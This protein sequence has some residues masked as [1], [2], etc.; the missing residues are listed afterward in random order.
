MSR[1]DEEAADQRQYVRRY[2]AGEPI[3]DHESD[4]DETGV[5]DEERASLLSHAV[6]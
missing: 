6:R 4:E 2:Q 1:W 5:S 3:D